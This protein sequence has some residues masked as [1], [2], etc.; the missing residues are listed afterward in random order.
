[1]ALLHDQLHHL[2]IFLFG[3][4]CCL[5]P[6]CFPQENLIIMETDNNQRI[7][8][9][10]YNYRPSHFSNVHI[11]VILGGVLPRIIPSVFIK[12]VYFRPPPASQLLTSRVV[13][14]QIFLLSLQHQATLECTE[15]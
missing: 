9:N 3:D 5:S 2:L 11:G 15:S 7:M 10:L 14:S 13:Y 6:P 8:A 4:A 12:Y 1:M